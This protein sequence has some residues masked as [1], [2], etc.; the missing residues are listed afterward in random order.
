MICPSFQKPVSPAYTGL[1]TEQGTVLQLSSLQHQGPAGLGA[2]A[3]GGGRKVTGPAPA[4]IT[5]N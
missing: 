3:D 5:D 4:G 1:E 2:Q